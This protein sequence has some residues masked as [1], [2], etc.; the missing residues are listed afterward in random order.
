VCAGETNA[1]DRAPRIRCGSDRT[2][3]S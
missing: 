1:H 2:L 3:R